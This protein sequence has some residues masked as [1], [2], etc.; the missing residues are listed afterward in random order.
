MKEFSVIAK[1]ISVFL[2]SAFTLKTNA[3]IIMKIVIQMT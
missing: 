2:Q 1:I 3:D